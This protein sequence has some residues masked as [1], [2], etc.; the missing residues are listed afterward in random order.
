M[1]HS[2]LHSQCYSICTCCFGQCQRNSTTPSHIYSL[3][4]GFPLLLLLASIAAES[5]LGVKAPHTTLHHSAAM[6]V[7]YMTLYTVHSMVSSAGA[8]CC[9]VPLVHKTGISDLNQLSTPPTRFDSHVL[10]PKCAFQRMLQC[11]MNNVCATQTF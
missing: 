1:W 6:Q 9:R 8:Q 3:L 5:K 2:V 10:L 11:D 7:I 4:A